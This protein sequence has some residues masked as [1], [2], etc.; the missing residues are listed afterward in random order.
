MNLGSFAEIGVLLG[1]A[2]VISLFMR[3]LKQPLIIG[4]IITGIIMGKYAMGIFHS[5]E[6][7]ELFSHLGIAFLLFSV[8][9]TLNPK[10]LKQYGFASVLNTFGQVFLTGGAGVLVC[11]LLGYGWITSLYVGV[12]ISF[13]STVIVLKLL[14]DKGDMDKLYVKVSIGSL[15]L[16]D[17]IAIILLFIIPMVSGAAGM[18][19]KLFT[20]IGLALLAG[21]GVFAFANY[22]IYYLHPYLSR[23]QELLFIF[24]NAWAIGVAILFQSIGLSLEGGALIA[25]VALSNLSSSHEIGARLAPLK[26]FFIVTFFIL[27]GTRLVVSD[28]NGILIP[29]LILSAFVLL[30]NP[31]IQLIVMGILGYRKKTSFQ[32]GMMAAQISEFSLILVGLGVSLN[33][34]PASVL[35]TVTLVG[36]VT[37]FIST[38][39]IFYSDK[40][41]N[42]LAPVLGIFERQSAREKAVKTEKFPI[43]L[44]GA[45]RVSYDFLKLFK[46]EKLKFLVLDHDPDVI[47]KLDKDGIRSEYGDVS[48]PDFLEDMKLSQADFVISTAPDLVTNHIVISVAKRGKNKPVVWVVSHRIGNALELYGAGADY[49]IM[50]HFLGGKYASSLLKLYNNGKVQFNNIKKKHILQLNER[51]VEGHEHPQIDRLR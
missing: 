39:F 28:F 30:I 12:A 23:S 48:D 26:D 4:H 2:T 13:S 49:V 6:T 18:G 24:A 7:L 41:Y 45:G 9:L 33:Q 11:M 5:Q 46:K 32:T 14:A 1:V 20:T 10:L 37:I 31:L 51:I 21:V 22:V 43:I 16:Q 19:T 40:L 50:P 42:F 38:Y 3:F 34:V 36:V 47:K 29:A 27:L 44:I 8:G 15:L 17:L 35:S 25:G